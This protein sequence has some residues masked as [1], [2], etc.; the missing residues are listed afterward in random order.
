MFVVCALVLFG[1][2]KKKHNP[3][4]PN[5]CAPNSVLCVFGMSSVSRDKLQSRGH[6]VKTIEQPELDVESP[7]VAH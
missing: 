7:P 2:E 3:D 1:G 6:I 5:D 4:L